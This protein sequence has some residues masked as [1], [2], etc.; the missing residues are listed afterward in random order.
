MRAAIDLLQ[1]VAARSIRRGDWSARGVRPTPARPLPPRIDPGPDRAGRRAA[2]PVNLLR[3]V[4]LRAA[5]NGWLQ[6]HVAGSPAGRRAAAR[7]MPGEGFDDA[8]AAALE[9]KRDSIASVLTHLG[10]DVSQLA[11]AEAAAHLYEDALRRLAGA[12][13]EAQVSVKPTQLGLGLG[14]E[15]AR[16]LVG[17]VAS[18][19]SDLGGCVWLDMEG[20]EHADGTLELFVEL[21]R[22]HDNVGLC[23]QSYLRRTSAD[24]ARLAP[25]N[26]RIR[27]VKG[28]YREPANVAY[29]RK[30]DVDRN[31]LELAV[32]LLKVVD[33]GGAAAFA[34]H[35]LELLEQIQ[36]SAQA[37][38]L[39]PGRY[40]IQMLY[41]IRPVP[42]RAL[43]AA[44]HAVRVLISYGT[45]WFPWYM[46]RLAERP[47]NLGFA[48]SQMIRP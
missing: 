32:E 39:R 16:R 47:A 8:L 6:S 24:L 23:L 21:A 10:E 14:L 38:G 28:A 18:C 9:L 27:L 44:G 42:Q 7:F 45:E 12:G 43:A 15:E 29:P 25:L 35:D 20:A 17:Q 13:I 36:N 40:E 30:R 5:K 1:V 19:A 3:P 41:G 37:L 34:T 4:L 48:L 11:E 2:D 22:A 31:Y 33:R 46:R 26:P